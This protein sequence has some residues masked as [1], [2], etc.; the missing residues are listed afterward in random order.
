[1]WPWGHLGVAYLLY[2]LY[3]RVRW[4]RPPRPE[5]VLA[6]VV[7]S[8][9]ADLVDKPLAWGLGILPGGRTLAHSLL[10]AAAVIGVCYAVALA[11]DRVETATAFAIAHL[12]H[13]AGDLPPRS[14][15]GYPY[16]T[17]FLF[18]PLLSHP[19]YGYTE[20]AFDPPAIV[21]LVV[22]P[23][24]DPVTAFLLDGALFV[25]A[26]GLWSVDGRPGL[27]IRRARERK[28]G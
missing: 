4:R 22:T 11:Y 25:L 20:R 21:E 27:E 13:L 24:A 19:A 28:R 23:F 14:L 12:A 9:F 16:G 26:L 6:V 7:G 5:P 18:W 2:S 3:A 1:M 15:L 8:Q 17:E 10:V